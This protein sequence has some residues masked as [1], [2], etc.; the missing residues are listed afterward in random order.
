MKRQIAG[1]ILISLGFGLFLQA[2]GQGVDC[3]TVCRQRYVQCRDAADKSADAVRA[4]K[5]C[6]DAFHTCLGNCV[7]APNPL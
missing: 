6:S 2:L 4:L 5:A 1:A 7:D 3:Q